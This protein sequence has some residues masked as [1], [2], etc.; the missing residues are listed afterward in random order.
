MV[1]WVGVSAA[2]FVVVAGWAWSLQRSL[3]VQPSPVAPFGRL[4]D[5]FSRLYRDVTTS[6]DA[7]QPLPSTPATTPVAPAADVAPPTTA[8]APVL[9]PDIL[10]ALQRELQERAA[11]S[12]TTTKP[13]P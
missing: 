3:V 6:L 8:P 1:L 7:M 11:A 9:T 10:E 12:E 4:E 5:D 2:M 13:Q